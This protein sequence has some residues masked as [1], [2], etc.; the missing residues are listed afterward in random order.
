MYLPNGARLRS[1]TDVCGQQHTWTRSRSV[2]QEGERTKF[3][4][5][6]DPNVQGA[7]GRVYSDLRI[8]RN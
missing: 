8:Y 2:C 6:V 4:R 3:D 5:F 7:Q 1:A